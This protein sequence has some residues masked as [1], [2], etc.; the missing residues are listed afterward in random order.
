MS[1]TSYQTA[2]PRARSY[3]IATRARADQPARPGASGENPAHGPRLRHPPAPR[4]R[5]RP[6]ARRARRRRLARRHAA[7]AATSCAQASPRPRGC[8]SLLTDRVDAELL[9]A[10]PKLRAIA[11]YAVGFDNIDLEAAAARGIPVGN[12]PDVLT[13]ATADLAFALMLA[14]RAPHAEAQPG[15]AA[16]ASGARGSRRAGSAPT[17]TAPR[18]AVV[19]AG[20][21]G[22]A[23]AQRAAGLRHGG[24]AWS[25]SATTCTAA[26]ERADFV[27]LHAPLTPET[28]HLIDADALARMKPTAILVNTARGAD[29]R[30]GRAR[31]RAARGPPRRRRPRRHRPRAAARPTTRCCEAP[32]LL[33][34]PHIGSATTTARA[35]DG[36]PRGRQPARRARRQ[37]D[38][39]PRPARLTR[40]DA[41]RRRRHRHELDAPARRRRRRRRHAD[42][43]RAPHEGHAAR[44][45]AR[46]DRRARA[47][48]RWSACSR[49]LRRVPRG[50]RRSRA[51]SAR[52]PCSRAPCA[53]PPTAPTFLARVRA[54]R[55]GLDAR[56]ICR[57][58][59]GA[60]DLP[61]RDERARAAATRR[62][63]LVI[64]VGGGS[65]ELVVGSGDEVSFHVS[66]QAGV[67][68][69]TERHLATDPPTRHELAPLAEDV[70]SI[71]AEAVPTERPPRRPARPSPSRAPRRRWAR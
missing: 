19:G 35:A 21:I 11:N 63:T 62:R 37:A 5:A 1:P 52:S 70:R 46:R 49:T 7:A 36:R 58:R 31:R 60:A 4:R 14:R 10:A 69:H 23:V 55:D 38:A 56:V 17:S 16:T 15:R 8:S 13:D 24:P 34:V 59:G 22:Q 30:P 6:P 47:T 67:V 32:N 48:R 39:L 71:F 33:V 68:R 2:P 40:R 3:T 29:R 26:L 51:P 41:R 43:A 61:R 64:D 9:D 66:T 45:S 50:H 53:T 18:S 57:R 27:S 28:R 42:R 12:T 20:R 25:T 65:T 44:R 54:Q